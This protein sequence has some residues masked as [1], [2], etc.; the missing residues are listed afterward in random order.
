[1]VKIPRR[2]L[3]LLVLTSLAALPCTAKDLPWQTPTTITG[4]LSLDKDG[5]I[6]IS[7]GDIVVRSESTKYP[8]KNIPVEGNDAPARYAEVK[9]LAEQ[10]KTAKL[11]GEFDRVHLH[12]IEELHSDIL[13]QLK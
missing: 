10:G 11:R 6:R 13:F 1:M 3:A 9:K 2:F 4:S 7:S 12:Q 8:V 5:G